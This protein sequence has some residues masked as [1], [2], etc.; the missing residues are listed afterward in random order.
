[1]TIL[2]GRKTIQGHNTLGY[3]SREVL[4]AMLHWV[5][6]TKEMDAGA[7]NSKCSSCELGN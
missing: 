4:K 6:L 3:C 1:M 5:G 7:G 2:T